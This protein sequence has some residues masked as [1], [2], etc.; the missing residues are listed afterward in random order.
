VPLLPGR[1]AQTAILFAVE[2]APRPYKTAIQNGFTTENA[3]GAS[4]PRRA[5][6]F[7]YTPLRRLATTAHVAATCHREA[8]SVTRVCHRTIPIYCCETL[9]K[10]G[11]NLFARL[12]GRAGHLAG[13]RGGFRPGQGAP[14][15][16]AAGGRRRSILHAE[17]VHQT[18]CGRSV[19]CTTAH[20][21]HARFVEAVWGARRKPVFF[22]CFFLR[23]VRVPGGR[24]TTHRSP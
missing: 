1:G 19:A 12:Y 16:E 4:P 23:P 18:R 3:E 8:E 13:Q 24:K 6:T 11:T 5:R 15:A 20:P 2:R 10:I 7:R 22:W 17:H 14:A 9:K 21:S